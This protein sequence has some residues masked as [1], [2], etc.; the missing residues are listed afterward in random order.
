VEGAE[1]Q[2]MALLELESSLERDFIS[3]HAREA[4]TASFEEENQGDNSAVLKHEKLMSYDPDHV[5]QPRFAESLAQAD[6]QFQHQAQHQ[7]HH[8]QQQHHS[9]PHHNSQHGKHHHKYKTIKK[10]IIERIPVDDDSEQ[11]GEEQ[12]VTE[13]TEVADDSQSVGDNMR[14]SEARAETEAETGATVK[15]RLHDTGGLFAKVGKSRRAAVASGGIFDSIKSA[16][17]GGSSGKSTKS[18]AQA[19]EDC[20]GCNFVWKQV[21][22]DI[23]SGRF[24][25]DVQA[26]FEHNCMDAQKSAIFYGVCEDMY[27]DMYA[28]TDDYMSNKYDVKAMCKRAKMCS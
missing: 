7:T 24:V 2:S 15:Q 12:P 13:E 27:D 28:M 8:K 23:G 18:K 3:L 21:E 22:M 19:L 25:E 9:A 11:D 14:F 17:G 20:T 1:G 26:S 10:V 5:S 4:A 6:S 16:L